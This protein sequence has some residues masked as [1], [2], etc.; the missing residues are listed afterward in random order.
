MLVSLKGDAVKRIFRMVAATALAAAVVL[1]GGTAQGYPDPAGP[2]IVLDPDACA[3]NPLPFSA[4]ASLAGDW[5]VTYD[6]HTR[7]GSGR[8]IE[9]TFPTAKADAGAGRLLTARVVTDDDQELTSSTNV[10]LTVCGSGAPSQPGAGLPSTGSD[11]SPWWIV[12]ASGA[13]VLGAG[14]VARA[15]RRPRRRHFVF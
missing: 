6:G 15:R 12:L 8:S 3:G 14:L 1:V 4:S 5:T 10:V 9:G 2:T 13:I 11:L 7:T